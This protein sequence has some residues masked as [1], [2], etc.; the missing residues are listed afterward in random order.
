MFYLIFSATIIFDKIFK[1]TLFM[2]TFIHLSNHSSFLYLLFFLLMFIET[3][4]A[5]L[6]FLPP[7]EAIVFLL[8]LWEAVCHKH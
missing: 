2:T 7:A 6:P 5:L 4:A 3:S 1:G 8:L